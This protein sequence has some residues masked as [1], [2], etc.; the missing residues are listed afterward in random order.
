M[1][2]GIEA[3]GIADRSPA[4]LLGRDDE[5]QAVDRLL[6]S[7]HEGLSGVLVVVGEAGMGKTALLDRAALAAT[8]MDVATVVGV[9]A[10]RDLG[11][12]AL[13]RLLLPFLDRRSRLPRPQAEALG[14]AF[15][16]VSGPPPDRFLVGLATLTL[17]ADVADD[18][19]LLCVVDDA[20]CLD[21]ESLDVLG[22]VGRRLLAESIAVL[23]GVRA[24][25]AEGT[26]LGD[27]PGLTLQ[28]LDDDAAAALLA[29]TA[30]GEVDIEVGRRVV[31]ETMGNPLALIELAQ[32]LTTDQLGGE[33]LL[34]ESLPLGPRLEAHY[35]RD[36]RALPPDA[37]AVLLLAAV[38][39][40]GEPDL[41]GRA[42]TRLGVGDGAAAAAEA[43]GL[44]TLR[45][46]IRFRHPLVRSA[47]IGGATVEERSRAH[48]ALAA[49]TDAELDPDR[50]AWHLAGAVLDADETVASELERA[51]ERA[52][53]RG[54][55]VGA[56]ALLVRAARITP[57]AKRRADRF[58]AAAEA[59]LGAGDATTARLLL[60][61]AEAEPDEPLRRAHVLR[62]DG[63]IR[64]ATGRI[65]E[66]P[67][68]L[69]AAAR[70]LEPFDVRLARDTL[71]AASSAAIYGGR[72][73][74]ST[75]MAE[76]ADAVAAV[77]LGPGTPATSGDVLLDG[78]SVLFTQ[79]HR[80]GAP[81][82]RRAIAALDAEDPVGDEA[83][84]WLGFGC[85]A[86]GAVADNEALRRLSARLV[87]VSR[88]RGALVEV[89][90]GLY[91]LAMGD[92]IAGELVQAA[93][94]FVEDRELIAA[95]GGGAALGEVIAMAW[96]GEETATRREAAAVA[97]A[98]GDRGQGGVGIYTEHALAVL[99][100]G[101]GHYQAAFEAAERVD[102]E[103]S[104]FLSTIALPD[105]VEA[106]TR[107]GHREAAAAAL[108]R[109]RDRAE[110]NATP[111]AL[112]LAARAGA[113]LAPD[114]EAEGLHQT[115]IDQLASLPAVGHLARA[116]L[117]YGEW[118]RRR[119]R[120]VDAREQLRPA[121]EAFAAI[122]ADGFA[123]R[124]RVELLATG[125]KARKRTVDT[126][127]DLT[128]QEL[129]IAQLAAQRATNGEI[130]AQLFISPGTVDY[131]LRKVFR[132]LG[133]TS[134]R[135][136]ADAL[137]RPEG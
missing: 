51:A 75:V 96:R 114:A 127:H 49:E 117:L 50:R 101:L 55:S 17:L 110:V 66:T 93:A 71:L 7:A 133:L 118:L 94:H 88:D 27:L 39:A 64:L 3:R 24:S 43:G 19:P 10:E 21:R 86:A 44:L 83:L 134:R 63:A 137:A 84:G 32:E 79:G 28:G 30:V 124:A 74:R 99:E 113:L 120:R 54:G 98:A 100:L 72:D 112:G 89:T 47:V 78:F 81:V 48:A 16:L 8:D 41:V 115:A 60:E 25:L 1:T 45:P 58:L 90:R 22:F 20:H 132:K 108:Q 131:H 52:R 9:E 34:P 104:Y 4:V 65:P 68:I 14:S 136:L 18:R 130:A 12:A 128:P 125:E 92:L 111:L 36:V 59:H 67:S 11:Y 61:E 95:R 38:D 107:S 37:Q 5:Q 87:Q 33:A 123:E 135:Q 15:G 23:F 126:A 85:W 46:R 6:T 97:R 91:F 129:K 102:A 122:G 106:G 73:A 26:R 40:S 29:T 105:L 13:H 77:P 119:N 42:A 53:S 116:R 109:C 82:L 56:G 2:S 80:A 121:H 31:A 70:A 76:V 103:D 35:L 62:L 57:D 69:L